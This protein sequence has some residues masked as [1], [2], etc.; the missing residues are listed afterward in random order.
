MNTHSYLTLT[1]K[2]LPTWV[3]TSHLLTCY[4]L[5]FLMFMEHS[6]CPMETATC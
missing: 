5:F 4:S 2:P 1:W 3:P 6:S